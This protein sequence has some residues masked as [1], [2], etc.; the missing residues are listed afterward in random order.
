MVLVPLTA[1]AKTNVAESTNLPTL[2]TSRLLMT[3]IYRYIEGKFVAKNSY[4]RS[5][6]DVLVTHTAAL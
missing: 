2:L 3:R 5:A 6:T 1:L 4:Q